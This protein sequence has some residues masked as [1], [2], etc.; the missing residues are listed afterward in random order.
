MSQNEESEDENPIL[1]FLINSL[2]DDR[3]QTQFC[4]NLIANLFEKG[5]SPRTAE[6]PEVK[7]KRKIID[8]YLKGICNITQ[9]YGIYT[10][11]INLPS[12]FHGRYLLQTD[13]EDI[14]FS[15]VF[16]KYIKI[17]NIKIYKERIQYSLTMYLKQF[18]VINLY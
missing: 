9:Q 11:K 6:F 14:E 4:Q 1:S 12:N 8:H 3:G 17:Y 10:I 5:T 18:M 7:I 15:K 2:T 13:D 16:T